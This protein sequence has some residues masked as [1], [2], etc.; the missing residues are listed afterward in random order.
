M[1][2]KQ[3]LKTK[4]D[5]ARRSLTVWTLGA[6]FALT[7]AMPFLAD[8]LPVV[9]EAF[10]DGTYQLIVRC[11]LIAGIVLRVRQAKAAK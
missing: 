7:E 4:L 2:L 6:G 11:T 3:Q 5:A 9:R 10:N 8:S 1:Q